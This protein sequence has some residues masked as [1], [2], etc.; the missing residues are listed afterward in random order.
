MKAVILAG[1]YGTRLSE[2]TQMIPKPMVE[3]GGKP[4]LWHIMKIYGCYGIKD[5]II[6]C[7]YKQYVIKEYFANYFRHNCDI[8]VNL[9]DN[10]ME[11][12]K[13][14]TEDWR[15]T[16]V[17][18]GLDTLTGGRVKRIQEYVGDEPFLLTYGDGVGD[19]DIAAS[20][21]AHK[22]SGRLLTMTTYQPSGKLGVVDI[23][24]DNTIT[25]F[26]E[27]PQSG[28]SWINAG[29]FVCEPGVFDVLQGDREMFEREPMQRLLQAGQLHAWRHT[30][31]W[32]PMDTLRD[33]QELNALWYSGNAPWKIW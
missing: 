18:T 27:K 10:T 2:A 14:H 32:K 3:I 8:R 28:G 26:R 16:M 20:I 30:G 23:A 1:G 21:E 33:N 7:G 12:L 9:A 15:V 22:A 17:D 5:F 11:V 24:A 29:F 25:G 4:I 13:T 6:C 19:I 31:F